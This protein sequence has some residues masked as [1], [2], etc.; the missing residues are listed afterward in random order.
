MRKGVLTLLG[1]ESEESIVSSQDRKQT[2]KQ[3]QQQQKQR[4][5]PRIGLCMHVHD[6]TDCAQGSSITIAVNNG[7]AHHAPVDAAGA[8]SPR[9]A[10]VPH[11]SE[12]GRKVSRSTGGLAFNMDIPC[13][14]LAPAVHVLISQPLIRGSCWLLPPSLAEGCRLGHGLDRP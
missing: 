5:R 4:S 7:R 9:A 1:F 12:V 14:P 10:D 6:T 8:V 3:T 11:V 13:R 2:N